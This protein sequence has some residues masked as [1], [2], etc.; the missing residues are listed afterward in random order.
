MMCVEECCLAVRAARES[1]PLSVVA[2][3]TFDPQPGG[4]YAS[5][6]GATPE[7]YAAAALDAGADIIAANCG[8][9]PD[10]MLNIVKLLRAALPPGFPILA[11]P[12]AGMPVV[13]E[14]QTYFPET[15]AEMATKVPLLLAAGAR[16]VGGCCGTTPA[17]IHAIAQTLKSP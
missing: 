1:T 17:H 8:V 15:P 16:C 6:M 4:G 9:G 14:G 13:R 10:H 3:F 12:N 5:L 2:S 7:Q 11:M